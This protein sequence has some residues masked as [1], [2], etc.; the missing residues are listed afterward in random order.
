M[1]HAA[2]EKPGEEGF[3]HFTS[4]RANLES[5]YTRSSSST[6]AG[7]NT[8]S[9]GPISLVEFAVYRSACDSGD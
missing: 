2:S 3:A 8:L 6:R 9:G 4:I 7:A 5:R 1:G